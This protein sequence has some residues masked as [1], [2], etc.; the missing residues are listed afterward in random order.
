MDSPDLWKIIGGTVL[1]VLTFFFGAKGVM[2]LVRKLLDGA[3]ENMRANTRAIDANSDA[4]RGLTVLIS[5]FI[6]VQDVR[7][8]EARH[9]YDRI[10]RD[11]DRI[12]NRTFKSA[13]ET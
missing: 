3:L 11:L 13:D 12:K 4:T 5:K 8:R 2:G 1:A 10:E 9:H 6:E 7:D